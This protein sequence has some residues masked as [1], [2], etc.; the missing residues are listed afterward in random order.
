M[1]APIQFKEFLFYQ[2]TGELIRRE[3][4]GELLV[5]RLAPQPSQLLLLLLENYPDIVE[6]EEILA[7]L[8][9]DVAVDYQRSLHFCVRQIRAA[10]QEDAANPR[11]IQTIPRRGYRW[12]APFE[13]ASSAVETK[14]KKEVGASP[15]PVLPQPFQF[16][17]ISN[18]ILGVVAIVT[19]SLFIYFLGA[20]QDADLPDKM[21]E[22]GQIRVAIMP[23]QPGKSDHGFA[24]NDIALRLVESLT[25]EYK[26]DFQIIGPTTTGAYPPGKIRALIQDFEVDWIINGRFSQVQDTSRLLAEVIRAADGAH[27]WVKYFDSDTDN[28]AIS[29]RIAAG[30]MA[31]SK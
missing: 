14:K 29:E 19:L 3:D 17:F 30:F 7:A 13:R 22:T 16:A 6:R 11:F 25:N 1:Q 15:K 10:L 23:F 9:P 5:S 28:S 4:S 18:K 12:I 27:V 24:G 20:W 31:E 8:W 2:E 21:A 26:S